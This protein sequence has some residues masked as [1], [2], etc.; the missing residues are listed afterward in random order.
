MNFKL[1]KST[2]IFLAFLVMGFGDVSGPLTSQLQAEFSLSNFQAGLVTFMAFI[3]FGLLS[4]PMGIYQDRKGRKHVLLLG[5]VAA[6]IGMGLPILGNYSSFVL[7]LGGLLFL[8]TGATM[9]QVAGNPI[10]RDVSPEGKYSRNLSYGQFVKAIG[11][12]SGSLIPILAARYWGMDWKLLFPIYGTVI[13]IV[14]VYLWFTK[15]EEKIDQEKEKP[16]TLKSCFGL[17]KNPFIALM[18]L[19][20]FV[21]V[22]SEVS[23]S[24]KLPNYLQMNFDF[25]IKEKGLFGTLFFFIALMSGRFMGGVIL[26]WL[27]PKKF[28]IITSILSLL[29]IGGLYFAGSEVFAF[30]FI[31]V[32]GLGFANIFPLIFSITV[33]AYPERS[34]EISGLMVTAIIGGAFV[35]VLFGVV[36]DMFGLMAGFLVP[37]FCILFILL[38]AFKPAK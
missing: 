33:D 30:V 32:I 23:M 22:G 12:L 15:V 20:I 19:G 11:S 38:I 29:G 2:V 34:N 8:G 6:L 3:M 17:L 13:L 7:I 28:L 4:V 18:V 9:L 14:V 21:Y 24:A 37:A 10:M 25:D 26:N 36:A 31:F 35:P 16:A 1:P 27:S 5:L